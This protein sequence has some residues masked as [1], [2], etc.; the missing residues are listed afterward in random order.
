MCHRVS[1]SSRRSRCHRPSR[2][3]SECLR[4]C[5]AAVRRRRTYRPI[6]R[7]PRY[8]RRSRRE[9]RAVRGRRRSPCRCHAFHTSDQSRGLRH[10]IPLESRV[11]NA[12]PTM[13][14]DDRARLCAHEPLASGGRLTQVPTVVA[15]LEIAESLQR[16]RRSSLV[17][18]QRQSAC[19]RRRLL[20]LP[21]RSTRRS[22]SM[23]WCAAI[24]AAPSSALTTPTPWR[25]SPTA[26]L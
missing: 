17:W 23:V 12:I 26:R 25:F 20:R 21:A 24:S 1:P 11:S 10:V 18:Q 4:G 13:A 19:Q 9:S 16:S 6:R 7:S 8:G 14:H 3:R 15:C 2:W 5:R 22:G